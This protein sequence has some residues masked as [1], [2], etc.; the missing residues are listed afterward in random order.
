MTGQSWVETELLILLAGKAAERLALQGSEAGWRRM[1]RAGELRAW[2]EVGHGLVAHLRGRTVYEMSI[3]IDPEEQVGPTPRCISGGSC[4]WGKLPERPLQTQTVG[5]PAEMDL[6]RSVRIAAVLVIPGTDT[7]LW[8]DTLRVMRD[9]QRRS[10][11]LLAAN[12]LLLVEL[13][14]ELEQ[15]Q[16]L[17]Q[18]D[19]AMILRGA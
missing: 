9:F 17:N 14:R 18:H 19:I 8:K 1:R 6:H 15:R 7:P 2:H 13:A 16:V 5:P 10:E 12:R 4:T 11:Y 3:V